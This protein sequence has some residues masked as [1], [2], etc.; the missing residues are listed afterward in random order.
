MSYRRQGVWHSINADTFALE[1]SLET[2]A[3]QP[4]ASAPVVRG[5]ILVFADR[6][7]TVTAIDIAK[8]SILWQTKLDESRSVDV[9][10]D[11]VVTANAVYAFAKGKLYALAL[12]S[13]KPLFPA[14]DA[15]SQGC[16][17][18]GN[19]WL[20]CAGSLSALSLAN[21]VSVNKVAV[22]AAVS[23]IPTISGSNLIVPLANGQI[24]VMGIE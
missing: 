11:P 9:F 13:G 22:P 4:V 15:S 24:M 16:I 20:G 5:S 6:K 23:G 1:N 21:G 2:G 12:A 17:A 19:L 7:G 10:I 3:V 14:V 18:G 8:S